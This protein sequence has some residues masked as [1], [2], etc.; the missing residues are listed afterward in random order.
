MRRYDSLLSNFPSISAFTH[1]TIKNP[2]LFQGGVI[3]SHNVTAALYC[4]NLKEVA[5]VDVVQ[6][7]KKCFRF[8]I[9]AE[10]PS[11]GAPPPTGLTDVE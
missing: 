8:E 4:L 3:K 1:I 11:V 5:V 9:E 2:R 10:L 6:V 7:V